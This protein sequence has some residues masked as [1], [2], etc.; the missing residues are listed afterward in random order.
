MNRIISFFFLLTLVSCASST[1]PKKTL[2]QKKAELYYNH[3]TNKL[4]AKDYT[5]ALDYL[6]KAYRFNKTDIKILNNLGMAYYFK[7]K[8]SKAKTYFDR[9][10]ELNPEHSDSRNNLASIHFTLGEYKSAL[11]QYLVV[12]ND[13][14]YKK[15][16][17]THYNIGLVYDK[18]KRSNKAITHLKKASELKEDYC[19]ALYKLGMIYRKKYHYSEALEWLNKAQKG[20]CHSEPAPL[21]QVG[22]TLMDLQ[23]YLMAQS[24][25]K[26]LQERFAST[27]YSTLANLQLRKIRTEEIIDRREQKLSRD[28]SIQLN[29]KSSIDTPSF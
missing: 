11:K 10:I 19:A 28:H 25:F 14:V 15:Q 8:Y 13:L 16:F 23:K 3:G 4:M 12:K 21:Y 17:R 2:N 5:G 27:R 6:I 29:N 1:V 24:K 22:L 7:K 9:A 26:E 18:L 20:A